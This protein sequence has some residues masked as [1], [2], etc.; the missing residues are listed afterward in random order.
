M[1]KRFTDS[2]KWDKG[3]FM[4]LSPKM[5][6]AWTYLCDKCDH[7][8][9]WDINTKLMSL[10]IGEDYSLDEI[11]SGLPGW[12]EQRGNKLFLTE[13]INFQYGNLN[14][15]NRVHKSILERVSKLAP[16]KPLTRPVEGPMEMDMEMEEE[17]E[18][19]KGGTG[20]FEKPPKP[21]HVVAAD[22][23]ECLNA[24]KETLEHFKIM[25]G[26]GER[27]QITIA[28]AVQSFGSEWVKLA[29]LGARKQTKSKNFDPAKF[30]SLS[31]YLHKD[32][33]ERLVNIG[34]GTESVEGLDWGSFLKAG[35]A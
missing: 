16:C 18:M 19:E 8:G 28:R 13:F 25:R 10:Q 2:G 3:S 17:L 21:H 33:I 34:A 6:L 29:L 27:D 12:I 4:D 20:G 35:A 11:L 1:A 22:V 31:I 24:W 7:A 14:P 9:V 23:S 30:V 32:R 26:V 15:D 5:K